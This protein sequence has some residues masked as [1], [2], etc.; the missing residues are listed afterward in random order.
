MIDCLRADVCY[1]SH[2]NAKTPAIDALRKRGST[3]TK[4]MSVT[5]TTTPNVASVF[6]GTY[7][8]RHGIRSLRGYKLAPGIKTI[9]EVFKENG[10][11][12]YGLVSGPIRRLETDIQRGFDV[13]D[14]HNSDKVETLFTGW[15]DTLKKDIKGFKG[16]WFAYLHLWELHTP[17]AVLKECNNSR[18]G[19]NLYER[20]LSSIDLRLADLFNMLPENTTV[21]ISGDHGENYQIPVCSYIRNKMTKIPLLNIK[22]SRRHP[23]YDHGYGLY[24][25]LINIPFVVA[26]PNIPNGI[27][28]DCLASQVDMMP[29]IIDM[30]G[31]GNV[32]IPHDIDGKSL[33]PAMAGGKLEPRPVFLD[34]T[35]RNIP[36]EK[37]WLKGIRTDEWK[38]IYAPKNESI[39]PLLYDLKNDPDE[40]NNLYHKLPD[41]ASSLKEI[42]L[43]HE[44][45]IEDR[46]MA[47]PGKKMT[48][49]ENK[50]LEQTLRDL[51]YVD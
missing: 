49:D 18:F 27:E 14:S 47:L 21:I 33:V 19:D 48:E 34:A 5:S 24:D 12:T 29:S 40:R 1:G 8:F 10:Y 44:T 6:T 51:G 31:L 4:M 30:A 42:L 41:K 7:P 38:F 39:E 25:F 26:G 9:A 37:D 3:F 16:P 43:Q 35:A 2:G 46:G 13:Y 17:R 20:S 50:D 45:G 22:P 11:N 36:S 32:N 23:K 28:V 15:F